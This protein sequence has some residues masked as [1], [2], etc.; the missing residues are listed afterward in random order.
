MAFKDL[1]NRGLDMIKDGAQAVTTA[2][3]EKKEAMQEFDLLKT[4][5]EHLGPLE[6]YVAHNEDPQDG[7]EQMILNACLTINV[8]N[9]KLVNAALP[10]DETVIDV[11]TGKEAQT[12]KNYNFVATDKR[13][14]IINKN[15]YM[16]MDY[17]AIKGC[18]IIDKGIMTQSVKFDDKAI[19]LDGNESDVK[20]FFEILKNPDLRRD[21]ISHKIAYLA[22]VVPRKQVLNMNMRGITIGENGNIVLHNNTDKLVVNIKEIMNV[23]VLINDTVALAHG[24]QE[25]SNFMSSPMEARKMAVK[26]ILT[27][28]EY[29]IDTMPQNAMNTSY[30]R[31]EATYTNNYN[32]SKALVDTL[33][34][35]ISEDQ[36]TSLK[37]SSLSLENTNQNVATDSQPLKEYPT[38]DVFHIDPK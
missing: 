10:I 23:Q 29:I 17:E 19:V 35:L 9:A 7:K 5:S 1:L 13:L 36:T 4:R 25:N 34:K 18:E 38:L 3:K 30:K 26:V 22:G 20:R 27:N 24:R 28:G 16:T 12:E 8:E 6:P 32:F 14:W 2:A 15:E 11:R 21:T 37:T 33:G 31:E